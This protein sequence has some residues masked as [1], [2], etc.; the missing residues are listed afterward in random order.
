MVP[1]SKKKKKNWQQP[2]YGWLHGTPVQSGN[3][4]NTSRFLPYLLIL[5]QGFI[6]LT[7]YRCDCRGTPKYPKLYSCDRGCSF[8]R[9]SMQS[10]CILNQLFSKWKPLL[11]HLPG[12]IWTVSPF[13]QWAERRSILHQTYLISSLPAKKKKNGITPQY[14]LE[15]PW[16]PLMWWV[17]KSGGGKE[18]EKE[19]RR[20][21]RGVIRVGKG[22]LSTVVLKPSSINYV[23]VNMQIIAN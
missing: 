15:P 8:N 7:F 11:A 5:H 16:T 6:I 1:L 2:R 20:H 4:I 17:M 13:Q 12:N 10:S 19:R 3:L 14:M 23:N 9:K 21:W 22:L 18:F